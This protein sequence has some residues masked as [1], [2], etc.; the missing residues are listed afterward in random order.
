MISQFGHYFVKNGTLDKEYSAILRRG[1]ERRMLGD[2]GQTAMVS[3]EVAARSI[4]EA[5]KFNSAIENLMNESNV[6]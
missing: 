2:Y 3:K 1:F 6:D 4:D 5:K